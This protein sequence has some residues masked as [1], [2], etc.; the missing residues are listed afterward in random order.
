MDE[1]KEVEEVLNRIGS[2]EGVTGLVVINPDGK[3]LKTSM[4]TTLTAQ[5]ST[6]C[7]NLSRIAQNVVRDL[8]PVDNLVTFRLSTL[9]H[10]IMIAP[11]RS[12]EGVYNMVTLQNTKKM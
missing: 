8:D 12:N 9:D 2:H 5:Y 10:E 11:G 7:K 1:I 6:L 4:D 3:V